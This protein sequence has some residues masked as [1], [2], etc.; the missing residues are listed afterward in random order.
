[1][2]DQTSICTTVHAWKFG[3]KCALEKV[4]RE[5]G[6]YWKGGSLLVFVP[7]HAKGLPQVF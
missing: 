3:V 2:D 1:M 6:T 4:R 5:G 7:R